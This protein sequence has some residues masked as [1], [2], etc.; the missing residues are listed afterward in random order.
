MKAIILAAGYAT[1]L[2]PLTL[3][4]PK[5][6]LKVG[7]KRMVEHIIHK[8]EE[9]DEI[10]EVHIV[11]NHKFHNH[12]LD[13]KQQFSS[14]LN[15]FV[16]NDGTA[17]EEDK[18]GAVG[19]MHF[20]IEKADLSG[21]V[22][23]IGGDN[24]FELS[25]NE[26]VRS[27]KNYGKTMVAARDLKDKALIAG[28]YGVIETDDQGRIMGF[29]EKPREPKSTLASTCIYL[30]NNDSIDELRSLMSNNAK[31]D[32]TGDLIKHLAQKLEVYTYN[33]DS[34]WFDIGNHDQLKEADEYLRGK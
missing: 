26:V 12:F 25:L 18:L 31:L 16:H 23:V 2:Y 30:F 28:R 3:D 29:E 7:G 19:D 5:P 33:F 27:F 24:L 14:D 32:N 22:L 9:T 6:L 4:L 8:I 20:V 34:R 1:R 11:T 15:I 10:D 13:W 17:S 21:D